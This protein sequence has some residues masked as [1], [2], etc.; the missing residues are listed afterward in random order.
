MRILWITNIMLPPICEAM[1]KSV[2]VTGGWM[3]S[4]LRELQKAGELEFAVATVWQGKEFVDKRIEGTR[5]YL[6]PLRGKDNQKYQSSLEDHWKRVQREFAPDVVHIHGTEFAHG[7]AYV[8]ACGAK[9]VVIS[10]QGLVSVIARYYLGGISTREVLRNVTFRDIVKRDNLFQQQRKFYKR[11]K[12]EQEYIRSVDH[13]IGRTSWDKAHVWAINPD[14][15]YHF[16]NETLR[17]EFYK[18][19]WKYEECEKHSIFLSQAGYPIKG[20][21]QVL[22]ALPLVL[23]HYPDTKLYVAGDD[24]TNR[25]W[26]RLSGYGSYIK[27]LIKG[28][29]LEGHVFFIGMLSETEICYRYLKSNLF[30]C[31]SSIENSPN[32]LGEAQLLGVPSIAA[33]VGG[34]P[35]MMCGDKGHI[36]RFEEPEMLAQKIC[37]IFFLGSKMKIF[38]RE[39]ALQRH[40]S[41]SNAQNMLSVY[42]MIVNA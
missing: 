40:G 15:E 25:E 6:L 19:Q 10:I 37:Q 3:Y 18:H 21:H 5:Y 35:D 39:V 34:V 8:R 14:V 33:Y 7:L 42:Q 38:D 11:G 13:V 29:K 28:N 16:C 22:K 26:F 2:P 20:L 32:S 24:I 17:S 12:I 27:R 41:D 36:Y 9:G 1:G 30:V 23:R 4:S 31:P